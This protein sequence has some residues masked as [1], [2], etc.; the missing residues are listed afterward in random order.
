MSG[1]QR[2]AFCHLPAYQQPVPGSQGRGPS[3][4]LHCHMRPVCTM[5]IHKWLWGWQPKPFGGRRQALPST[6]GTKAL[7]LTMGRNGPNRSQ[8]PKH[9][10]AWQPG[11]IAVRTEGVGFPPD[12]RRPCSLV[13]GL[14]TQGPHWSPVFVEIQGQMDAL[15]WMCQWSKLDVQAV[16]WLFWMSFFPNGN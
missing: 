12:S 15:N 7:P 10:G 9:R 8:S 3:P 6:K 4:S 11:Q 5:G 2:Q 16:P 14:P 13:P 1:V